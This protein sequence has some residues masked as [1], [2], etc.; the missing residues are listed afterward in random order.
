MN[1]AFF[2]LWIVI[3]IML[4]LFILFA[5]RNIKQI[6]QSKETPFQFDSDPLLNCLPGKNIELLPI[7]KSVCCIVNNAATTYQQYTMSGGLNVVLDENPY[8]YLLAC[9]GFCK[10]YNVLQ[11]VCEDVESV[12]PEYYNCIADTKPVSGCIQT[13]LPVARV[14]TT[15]YYVKEATWENCTSTYICL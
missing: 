1:Y 3:F 7:T 4:G 5:T 15:P 12:D 8:N 9:K 2:I 6:A 10:N 14:G 13:A 11:N